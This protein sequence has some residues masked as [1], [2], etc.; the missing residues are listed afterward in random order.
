LVA[1]YVRVI[2][3]LRG[4][5]VNIDYTNSKLLPTQKIN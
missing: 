3:L 1:H 2:L 5:N 4:Q